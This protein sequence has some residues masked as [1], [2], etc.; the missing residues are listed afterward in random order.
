MDSLLKLTIPTVLSQQ[1]SHTPR[2]LN[3]FINY[4][5]FESNSLD[6]LY[7]W[8]DVSRLLPLLDRFQKFLSI[9]NHSYFNIDI[10]LVMATC[11]K[12]LDFCIS[13]LNFITNIEKSSSNEKLRILICSF[14]R[15]ITFL[16]PVQI[17][18]FSEISQ[19]IVDSELCSKFGST[20]SVL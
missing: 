7:Y 8:S 15:G 20:I 2:F 13:I 3:E 18:Q 14:I 9:L 16:S 19:D 5:C 12:L 1:D 11:S 10:Q 6:E 4:V 17:P